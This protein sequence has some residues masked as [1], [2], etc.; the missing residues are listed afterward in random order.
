MTKKWRDPRKEIMSAKEQN[1]QWD[2][3]IAK[4]KKKPKP[5][6]GNKSVTNCHRVKLDWERIWTEFQLWIL[7][8]NWS[9]PLQKEAIQRIV[10]KHIWRAK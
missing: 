10:E 3:T 9:W 4:F 6:K 7:R 1:E 2:R 8:D 5:V